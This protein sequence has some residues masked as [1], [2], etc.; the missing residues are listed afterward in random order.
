MTL[1]ATSVLLRLHN[2]AGSD[3]EGGGEVLYHSSHCL[4]LLL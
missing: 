3:P 4:R 1:Q 2:V